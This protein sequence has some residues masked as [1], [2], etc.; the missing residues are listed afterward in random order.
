LKSCD[1]IES[2]PNVAQSLEM[3]MEHKPRTNSTEQGP[4]WENNRSSP[5]QESPN[6]LTRKL[7]LVKV[8]CSFSSSIHI[9]DIFYNSEKSVIKADKM[10]RARRRH[11]KHENMQAYLELKKVNGRNS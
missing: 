2:I 9:F 5:V 1:L 10:D 3:R 8:F 4:S 7:G 11:K 6:Y